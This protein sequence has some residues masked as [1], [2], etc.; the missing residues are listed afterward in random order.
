MS[1][2]LANG[3]SITMT[4]G[5]YAGARGQVTRYDGSDFVEVALARRN[6]PAL[7]LLVRRSDVAVVA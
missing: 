7:R 4:A 2:R 5:P 3:A 6:M 1:A